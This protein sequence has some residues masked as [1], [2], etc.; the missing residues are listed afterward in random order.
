LLHQFLAECSGVAIT[1][2]ARVTHRFGRRL[3]NITANGIAAS[4]C[5]HHS[6]W[7]KVKCRPW[8]EANRHRHELFKNRP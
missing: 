6:D 3:I 2:R 8:R 4:Y 5:S 1:K 7:L